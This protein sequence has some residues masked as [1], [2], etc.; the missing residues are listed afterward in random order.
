LLLIALPSVTDIETAADA[1]NITGSDHDD[2]GG[3]VA[4]TINVIPVTMMP[5]SRKSTI[6]RL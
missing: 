3:G 4:T 1:V 6:H 2:D 5:A